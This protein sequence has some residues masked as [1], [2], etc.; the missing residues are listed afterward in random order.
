MKPVVVLGL[1]GVAIAAL[2]FVLLSDPSEPAPK[3]GGLGPDSSS[4]ETTLGPSKTTNLNLDNTGTQGQSTGTARIENVGERAAVSASGEVLQGAYENGING[5]V[6]DPD[7]LPVADATV[8][9]L[10]SKFAQMSILQVASEL[11][12][13]RDAWTAITGPD[14]VFTFRNV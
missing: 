12:G 1:V 10:Q 5:M 3:S 7:G 8:T 6:L 13:K 14:G 4:Q 9:L 2:L 11:T